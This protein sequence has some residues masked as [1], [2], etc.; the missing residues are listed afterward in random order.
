MHALIV[1]ETAPFGPGFKITFSCACQRYV[2]DTTLGMTKT[3]AQERA[4][5]F[6]RVHAHIA[7][8]W[9]ASAAGARPSS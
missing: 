2:N 5:K 1:H 7:A 3:D 9:D 6:I 8:P 4:E